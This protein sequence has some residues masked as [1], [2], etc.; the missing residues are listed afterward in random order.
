M[1]HSRRFRF[2][3]SPC[4]VVC[5]DENEEQTDIVIFFDA[6]KLRAHAIGHFANTTEMKNWAMLPGWNWNTITHCTDRLRDIGCPFFSLA[7]AHLPPC[8]NSGYRC[9]YDE[10]CRITVRPIEDAYCLAIHGIIEEIGSLPRYSRFVDKEKQYYCWLFSDRGI[11]VKMVWNRDAYN[12][13]T[14][15]KPS[16][17][18]NLPWS[19]LLKRMVDRIQ[20]Q[21]GSRVVWCDWKTWGL[22]HDGPESD[23]RK[24]RR[25]TGRS[26]RSARYIRGGGHNWRQFLDG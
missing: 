7:M 12:V 19:L 26:G 9:P 20:S 3:F 15:F 18:N 13:M 22:D 4:P 5:P 24:K 21:G 1:E 8:A 2:Q 23:T 17:G 6:H 10:I 11:V 25:K 14:A 16:Q